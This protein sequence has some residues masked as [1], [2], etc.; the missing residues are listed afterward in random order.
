[1]RTTRNWLPLIFLLSGCA[2]PAYPTLA[3]VPPE[4][5]HSNSWGPEGNQ[6]R[7]EGRLQ[8]VFYP[9]R[10]AEWQQL[11]REH[12]QDGDIL[13][14]LGKAN[15][16]TEKINSW[17]IASVCDSR[18]SHEGMARWDGDTL[19]IY[20]AEPAPE[21]IR[22]VP[23]VFW[24]LDTA[25][26]TLAIKRL[27]EPYRDH[28][29]E[30]LAYCEK[31]YLLQ[32]PYDRSLALDDARYYCSELIEKAYLSTGIVLSEPVPIRCLPHYRRYALLR[33]IIER[34]SEIRADTAIFSVGNVTYGQYG[35]PYLELVYDEYKRPDRHTKG[36][37]CGPPEP[38]PDTN[39]TVAIAPDQGS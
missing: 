1:M 5:R 27:K 22:K 8:P 12:I 6:A 39:G 38:T 18:F 35:S 34:F 24:M 15:K 4:W 16:L 21:G 32:P 3:T 19:Y 30:A 17:F 26:H 33:P 29:P 28:I 14:R 36:P 20:D 9:K 10:A 25:D 23:F 31:I 13:F 11:A 37:L 7:A 2:V